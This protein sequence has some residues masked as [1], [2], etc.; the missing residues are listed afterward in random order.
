MNRASITSLH[1]HTQK[2]TKSTHSHMTSTHLTR[3]VSRRVPQ[4]K[5]SLP[6]S[7]QCGQSPRWLQS[8]GGLLTWSLWAWSHRHIGCVV[9][10]SETPTRLNT[11]SRRSPGH[12]PWGASRPIGHS[13][14]V[15]TSMGTTGEHQRLGDPRPRRPRTGRS[16][17]TGLSRA[18]P[19]NSIIAERVVSQG[20]HVSCHSV[21]AQR[22]STSS[23]K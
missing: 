11:H 22:H 7:D 17:A 3:T 21:T 15:R 18:H 8:Q 19:Y 10:R 20:H 12:R 16:S 13:N 23:R 14:E 6:P 5:D 4:A 1:T 2:P 9:E